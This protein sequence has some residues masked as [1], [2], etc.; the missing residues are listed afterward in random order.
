[1]PPVWRQNWFIGL[2]VIFLGTTLFLL[3]RVIVHTRD[4]DRAQRELI[5]RQ[6]QELLDAHDMQMGLMPKTNPQIPG[7]DLAG[8]CTPAN[9]VSGDFFQYF[10][11]QNSL[12]IALADVTGHAMA[13]A[14]PAVMFSGI[15]E[16]QMEDDRDLPTLYANLNRSLFRI[17]ESHTFICLAMAKLN[18]DTHTLQLANA[19]CPPPYFYRVATDELI[20]LR[21]EDYP[22]GAV[23][24]AIHDVQEIELHPHDCL[25]F[26]SDGLAEI[27][28][29]AGDQLGYQSLS[30]YIGDACRANLPARATLD[31]IQQQIKTFTNGLPGV[32]D[33]TC[34]VLRI[35]DT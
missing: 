18:L 30:S 8:L 4:R 13:A 26:Y 20:E 28:N 29:P 22:L 2:I 27:E 6:E 19:G 33:I 10:E 21:A 25:I 24:D 7:L 23:P 17:L 5:Q 34:I 12:T 1:V 3:S 32:D 11:R 16:N 15:L 35:T 9:H 14:I 31:H